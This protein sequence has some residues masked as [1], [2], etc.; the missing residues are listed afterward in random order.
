MT[1]APLVSILDDEPDIRE[2]L[3]HTLQ[4]AGFRTQGFGRARDFEAALKA[5]QPD[6]C[7]V[8]LSLPDTDGLLPPPL[9]NN[10]PTV[11]LLP[12]AE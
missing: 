7:L 2:M 4:E 1:R 8:D 12:I 9:E 11:P 5:H 10:D 3:A 6:V